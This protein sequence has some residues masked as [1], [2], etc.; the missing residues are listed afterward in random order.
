MLQPLS[1]MKRNDLTG[2]TIGFIMNNFC[3]VI[4]IPSNG[5]NVPDVKNIITNKVKTNSLERKKKQKK[6]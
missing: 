4:D 1:I 3:I 6:N 5:H 2:S